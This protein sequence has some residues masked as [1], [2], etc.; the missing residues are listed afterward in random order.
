[1]VTKASKITKEIIDSVEKQKEFGEDELSDTYKG[2][3]CIL[4]PEESE[5]AK[6]LKL[7]KKGNFAIKVG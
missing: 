7:T 4:K 2:R 3:V 6:N 5:I 1:M